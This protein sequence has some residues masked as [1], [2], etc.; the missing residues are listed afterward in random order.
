MQRLS[1]VA[2]AVALEAT[3]FQWTA[4]AVKLLRLMLLQHLVP[5]LLMQLAL[6]AQEPLMPAI[7]RVHKVE[8]LRLLA[9]LLL[10]VDKVGLILVAVDKVAQL[11]LQPWRVTI[12]VEA[13]EIRLVE[14]AA[15]AQFILN[16]GYKEK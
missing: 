4:W 6:G 2:V 12:M 3:K 7:L 14:Q 11:V 5:L 15:Q 13:V 1:A 16:T 10:Q 9:Q 8:Q